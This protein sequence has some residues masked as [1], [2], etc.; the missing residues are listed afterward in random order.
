MR[1]TQAPPL[2]EPLLTPRQ[3][4]RYLHTT[5]ARLAQDRHLGRGLPF[6]RHG[7][8]ILYRVGEIQRYLDTGT[9]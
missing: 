8:N 9:R 3:V 1:T 7:R 6:V 5:E 4:A 2:L